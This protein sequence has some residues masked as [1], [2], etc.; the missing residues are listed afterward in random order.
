MIVDRDDS[1]SSTCHQLLPVRVYVSTGGNFL[2]E[3]RN[4]RHLI[5]CKTVAIEIEK[6]VCEYEAE[7]AP[8]RASHELYETLSEVYLAPLIPET[9]VWP[10]PGVKGVGIRLYPTPSGS[11][12]WSTKKWCQLSDRLDECAIVVTKNLYGTD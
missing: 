11:D 4:T 3:K 1:S 9:D 2:P 7:I 5:E 6:T 10:P 12:R 8:S